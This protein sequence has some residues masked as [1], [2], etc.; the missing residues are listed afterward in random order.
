MK[1]VRYSAQGTLNKKDINENFNEVAKAIPVSTLVIKT[2]G[3]GK[4]FE[5][6]HDAMAWA[7][8]QSQVGNGD[9][10]LILDD[11]VHYVGEEITL[12]L[13]TYFYYNTKGNLTIQGASYDKTLCSITLPAEGEDNYAGIFLQSN[14]GYLVFSDVT[15]D[16]GLGGFPYAHNTYPVSV[17]TGSYTYLSNCTVKGGYA[18]LD[19]SGGNLVLRNATVDGSELGISSQVGDIFIDNGCSLINC[20]IAIDLGTYGFGGFC[21]VD[22]ATVLTNNTV[23]YVPTL[24]QRDYSGNLITDG[25]G[26]ITDKS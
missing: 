2:V 8:D 10:K 11:G 25:S 1:K 5:L 3:I 23:D 26:P 15:F 24:N 18:G 19:I 21:Q 4:D 13:N 16:V 17:Y 6:F 9:I 14:G 20:G 12:N 22:P 7:C